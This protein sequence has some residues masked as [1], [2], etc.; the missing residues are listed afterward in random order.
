MFNLLVGYFKSLQVYYYQFINQ[1][2]AS[3]MVKIKS[4]NRNSFA[5]RF[6]LTTHFLI[7]AFMACILCGTGLF[8]LMQNSEVRT[9]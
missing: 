4:L 9:E 1:S 5:A 3:T 7:L 2:Q 6:K 8:V